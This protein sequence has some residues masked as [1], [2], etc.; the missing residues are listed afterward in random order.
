MKR[1]LII[2][3]TFLFSAGCL[4]S[5][6]PRSFIVLRDVPANPTFAVLSDNYDFGNRM[7]QVIIE[8]GVK[9][10]VP[11][12]SKFTETK[13]T[14]KNESKESTENSIKQTS[15]D[16]IT[17]ADYV[18]TVDSLGRN[19]YRIKIIK[20]KDREILSNFI[21]TENTT[22]Q[23]KGLEEINFKATFYDAFNK[24]GLK[25]RNYN[26]SYSAALEYLQEKK[27]KLKNI[28]DWNAYCS[29]G[30]KPFFIPEKPDVIY[31]NEGW[32]SWDEWIKNITPQ[33]NTMK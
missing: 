17:N 4:S 12:S 28:D 15:F 21:F 23:K 7:E 31:K 9:L 14:A 11:P 19:S 20:M 13:Q 25:V 3:I 32:I 26:A 29:D 33:S 18:L 22:S 16:L 27:L 8:F 2:L 10:F 5:P 6:E 24:M 1:F 30:N